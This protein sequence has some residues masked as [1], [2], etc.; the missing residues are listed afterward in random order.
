MPTQL[1]E[2]DFLLLGYA[3]AELVKNAE[4]HSIFDA[5][6]DAGLK[7]ITER[8]IYIKS[9]ASLEDAIS[10]ISRY[11]SAKDAYVIL[12]KSRED[13]IAALDRSKS[14]KGRVFIYETLI[15][16]KLEQIFG[17]YVESLK[18]GI[19]V[20]KPFVPA[21]ENSDPQENVGRTIIELLTETPKDDKRSSLLDL[22]APAGLGKTSVSRWVAVELAKMA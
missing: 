21:R 22:L 10:A 2:K 5:Q 11:D 14:I 16:E 8:F 18:D 13:R 20:P 9:S 17:D 6:A 12:P 19:P 3:K 4:T 15:W 1:T 7:K